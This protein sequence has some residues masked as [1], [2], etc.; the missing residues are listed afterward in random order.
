MS[1]PGKRARLSVGVTLLVLLVLLVPVVDQ[2]AFRYA[3]ARAAIAE[4]ESRHARMRGLLD[5]APSLSKAVADALAALARYAYGAEIGIDRI[6]AELQ[7]RVRHLAEE[8]GAAVVGSQIL[9][10][11]AGDGLELVP[12]A[13]T[14]DADAGSLRS[15][16]IALE[17]GTPSIQVDQL[18]ITTLRQRSA[19]GDAF[20]VQL[21]LSAIRLQP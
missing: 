17:A 12:L 19:A 18:T 3:W 8:A 6:G 5:A 21:V 14:L 13:V 20:R 4:L 9:P 11:R 7:Q 15:L 1:I 16:L 2:L 10:P